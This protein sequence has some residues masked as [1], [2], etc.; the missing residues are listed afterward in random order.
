VIENRVMGKI[1]GPK[2]DEM[3]GEC[4]KLHDEALHNLYASSNIVR[5]IKSSRTRLSG[6]VA[7][8]EEVYKVLVGKLR[9]K[10]TTWKTKT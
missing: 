4:R 2:R 10:E 7:R 1:F 5:Q 6:H 8:M 3:A 9:R